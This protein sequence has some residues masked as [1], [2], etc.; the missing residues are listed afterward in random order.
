MVYSTI[1]NCKRIESIKLQNEDILNDMIENGY[2][3]IKK[4]DHEDF[5]KIIRFPT[6]GCI[7]ELYKMPRAYSYHIDSIKGKKLINKLCYF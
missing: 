4:L 2:V 3:W 5:N 7:V 1:F 6:L